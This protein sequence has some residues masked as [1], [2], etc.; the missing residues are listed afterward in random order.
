LTKWLRDADKFT[1][2]RFKENFVSAIS[3][4][5]YPD[6]LLLNSHV[7]TISAGI[8]L[9]EDKGKKMV[10]QQELALSVELSE[11]AFPKVELSYE[12]A[13]LYLRREGISVAADAPR[14]YVVA[15][16]QGHPLGFLNNLGNR[17]NN[18][19][20]TE[21]RIRSSYTPEA[22]TELTF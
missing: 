6:F 15:T 8:L 16:F 18:L 9:A 20:P 1:I 22:A 11:K 7:H 5:I 3:K 21:W 17:A 19:Y 10:P 2:F 13:I 4:N 14:G 12:Q